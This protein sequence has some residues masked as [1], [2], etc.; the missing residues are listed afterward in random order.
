MRIDNGTIMAIKKDV[1]YSGKN[2]KFSNDGTGVVW[3]ESYSKIHDNGN[4]YIETDDELNFKTGGH[5]SVQISSNGTTSFKRSGV[6]ISGGRVV[7]YP[8]SSGYGYVNKTGATGWSWSE[9]STFSLVANYRISCSEV[10]CVSDRRTKHN[11][12]AFP[13]WLCLRVVRKL[14][15]RMYVRVNECVHSCGFLAQEV[16]KVL[17]QAV[18]RMP[19]TVNGK[20][21]HDCRV[22]DYNQ[23][24]AA[25]TGAIRQL[26][27]QVARLE[28]QINALTP[29]P[30]KPRKASK[31]RLVTLARGLRVRHSHPTRDR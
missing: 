17:P 13:D 14:K 9:D 5:V 3:G 15:P 30:P 18:S 29:N 28:G 7:S 8:R 16:E 19:K 4:L 2:I 27:K 23:L 20:R 21:I 22:L 24:I 1:V 25:N 6:Y 11:I 31:R 10:N 12:E 26:S